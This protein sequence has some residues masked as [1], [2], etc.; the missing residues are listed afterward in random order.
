[1]PF[2]LRRQDWQ[3]NAD[4]IKLYIDLFLIN[5]FGQ[6][7]LR[8]SRLPFVLHPRQLGLRHLKF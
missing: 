5:I 1:M 8:N 2:T 7:I 4:N 3:S 6:Q